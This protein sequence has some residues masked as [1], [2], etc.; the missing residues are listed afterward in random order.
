MTSQLNV[1]S[2]PSSAS[3]SDAG[4]CPVCQAVFKV[5]GSSGV[6]RKHG[7]GHGRPPCSGSGKPPLAP[8]STTV[9]TS[10]NHINDSVLTLDFTASQFCP[11]KP[12]PSDRP[13]VVCL[14]GLVKSVPKLL[15]PD[16]VRCWLL[17]MISAIGEEFFS[18]PTASHN[19]VE[20][21]RDIA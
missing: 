20:A 13:F 5:V 3:S 21:A 15:K 7:H 14:A 11:F 10:A 2:I 1:S 9:D 19:L 4:V 17:P 8:P 16:C 12:T 18:S 6:V